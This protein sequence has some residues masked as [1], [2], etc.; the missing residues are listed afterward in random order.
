MKVLHID[1]DPT[2]RLIITKMLEKKNH[3]VISANDGDEGLSI[4]LDDD[5]D[6]I[7]IDMLMPKLSGLETIKI[8]QTDPKFEN[9]KNIPIIILTACAMTHQIREFQ[10][11]KWAKE[12]IPKPV[13][14]NDLLNILDKYDVK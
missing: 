13:D 12:I 5:F 11:G 1:D 7:L 3:I 2:T 8:I 10:E 9:K 6:L 14:M 4:L